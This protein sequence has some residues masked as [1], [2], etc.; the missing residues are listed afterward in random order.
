MRTSSRIRAR[1]SSGH[2]ACQIPESVDR[3][4]VDAPV[5]TCTRD[6]STTGPDIESPGQYYS[7][8]A[9]TEEE[10]FQPQRGV[11]APRDSATSRKNAESKTP[12]CRPAATH[13]VVG[14]ALALLP[15]VI[16][17]KLT[18]MLGRDGRRNSGMPLALSRKNG[19]ENTFRLPVR[20]PN[21]AGQGLG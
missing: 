20:Y 15:T 8:P 11:P 21:R 3:P 2:G 9:E 14:R 10:C 18:G 13:D 6:G 5:T 4:S 7:S 19:R 16:I 12:W 17:R 1:D